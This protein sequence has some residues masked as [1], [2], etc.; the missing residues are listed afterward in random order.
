[1]DKF[2]K[3]VDGLIDLFSKSIYKD[4]DVLSCFYNLIKT[5]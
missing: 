1:L 3:F 2:V 4:L 5:K